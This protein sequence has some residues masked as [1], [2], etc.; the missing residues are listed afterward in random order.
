[1]HLYALT[2]LVLH[3]VQTLVTD[4]K[5]LQ[6]INL[7]SSQVLHTRIQS[8]LTYFIKLCNVTVIL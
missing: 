6:N 5:M 3:L 7:L 2:L 1:M 4:F 8:I